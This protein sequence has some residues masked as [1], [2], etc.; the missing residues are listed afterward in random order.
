MPTTKDTPF[1]SKSN[2]IGS[3]RWKVASSFPTVIEAFLI[4]GAFQ[5]L[6]SRWYLV[7]LEQHPDGVHRI[8]AV[9]A[10]NAE[11]FDLSPAS[12]DTAMAAS[13]LLSVSTGTSDVSA[14][15]IRF[16]RLISNIMH[17]MLEPSKAV[18]FIWERLA[19]SETGSNAYSA[20]GAGP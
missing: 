9:L 12:I 20:R 1:Y 2:S 16:N 3:V 14:A 10:G 17:G 6:S 7:W 8:H 13:P 5:K 11:E 19:L 4:D 15:A 18:E